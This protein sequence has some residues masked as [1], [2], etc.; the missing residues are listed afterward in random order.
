MHQN[1]HAISVLMNPAQD[2]SRESLQQAINTEIKALDESIKAEIRS[3]ELLK[4]R[5]NAL[6][7]ISS[8]PPE[9]F[10][11]IFSFL[12]LPGIT[13]LGEKPP[14]NRARLRISHVVCHQWR[15]IALNQPQLWSHVTFSTVSLTGATDILHRAKSMPLFMYCF[16]VLGLSES[17]H[18]LGSCFFSG[19]A[20]RCG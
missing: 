12:C 3:L 19:T 14:R 15:G 20:S 13:P 16:D 11:T 9:I 8:L 2:N 7:P 18:R 1:R 10:A 4:L 17:K 5:R 6:Q